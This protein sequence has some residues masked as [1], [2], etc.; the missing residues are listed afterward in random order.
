MSDLSCR[1]FAEV[2]NWV[3]KEG[4]EGTAS[5]RKA[6][7]GVGRGGWRDFEH[8]RFYQIYRAHK[9]FIECLNGSFGKPETEI[10]YFW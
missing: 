7:T 8:G 9:Y 10:Y 3:V 4:C 1:W 2:V 5:N 6:L